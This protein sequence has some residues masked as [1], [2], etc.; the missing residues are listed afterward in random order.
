MDGERELTAKRL[1]ISENGQLNDFYI[2]KIASKGSF[3]SEN[4]QLLYICIERMDGERTF[5]KRE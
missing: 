1:F 5:Y 4:E 3:V 2:Q